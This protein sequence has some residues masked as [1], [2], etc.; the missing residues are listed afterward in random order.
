MP[1]GKSLAQKVPGEVK[2]REMMN[3]KSYKEGI[4]QLIEISG[5]NKTAVMC[6][7]ENPAKCH[8]QLLIT[9]SLLESRVKVL[10]IRGS[11]KIEDAKKQ[12]L[13]TGLFGN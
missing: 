9:Q 7:E 6:S 3:K 10:H 5:K 2:Y 4:S 12:A 11:G 1:G 13:K 8:R